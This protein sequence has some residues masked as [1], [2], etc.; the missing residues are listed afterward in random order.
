MRKFTHLAQLSDEELKTCLQN[1]VT[2][3]KNLRKEMFIGLPSKEL[4]VEYKHQKFVYKELFQHAAM[5][6]T[7]FF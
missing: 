2:T 7:I 5:R 3:L 1:V 6:S 4:L